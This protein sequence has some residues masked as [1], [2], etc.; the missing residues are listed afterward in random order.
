MSQL[1]TVTS[2]LR[3]SRVTEVYSSVFC[4]ADSGTNTSFNPS[5]FFVDLSLGRRFLAM[6]IWTADSFSDIAR[7]ILE[8][9][10]KRD[11]LRAGFCATCMVLH[12]TFR[13]ISSSVRHAPQ[14][15][16]GRSSLGLPFPHLNS[17]LVFYQSINQIVDVLLVLLSGVLAQQL[18]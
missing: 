12:D 14:C 5:K 16:L 8:E 2:I 4:T 6:L 9:R 1:R 10:R 3:G 17:N 18:K 15:S 7:W 13:S 11:S